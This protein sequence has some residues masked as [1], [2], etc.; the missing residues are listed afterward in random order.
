MTVESAKTLGFT[1][2]LLLFLIHC[3]ILAAAPVSTLACINSE[4]ITMDKPTNQPTN[5]Y[6]EGNKTE[7]LICHLNC[8]EK[9]QRFRLCI[10]NKIYTYR[11]PPPWVKI[12]NVTQIISPNS[13][14]TFSIPLQLPDPDR[15]VVTV[16]CCYIIDRV[17]S[18]YMLREE[19]C[20]R[21]NDSIGKVH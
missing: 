7:N 18:T 21:R 12:H 3:C 9:V 17:R 15:R 19:Y 13:S 16:G 5:V 10:D 4:E 8:S 11:N 20:L 2:S 1:I 14:I 6:I